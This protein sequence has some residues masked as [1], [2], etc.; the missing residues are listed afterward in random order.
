MRVWAWNPA[1]GVPV[2]L[3]AAAYHADSHQAEKCDLENVNAYMNETLMYCKLEARGMKVPSVNI[4]FGLGEGHLVSGKRR[5]LV[6]S[7]A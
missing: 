7:S 3:R 4:V 1:V 5:K 2:I 6:S